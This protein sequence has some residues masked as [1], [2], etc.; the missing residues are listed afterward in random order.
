[1]KSLKKEEHSSN[2]FPNAYVRCRVGEAGIL[3]TSTKLL[4]KYNK[5]REKSHNFMSK[6]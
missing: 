4:A 6:I 1:M 2:R 3:I 5:S